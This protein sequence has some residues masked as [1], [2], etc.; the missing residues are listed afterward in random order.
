MTDWIEVHRGWTV[1]DKTGTQW[2]VTDRKP[3]QVF[4]IS[5]PGKKT[6][7]G[8]F[9]GEVDAV[10]P[11]PKDDERLKHDIATAMI[12]VRLGGKS[13]GK[14]PK[15]RSLPWP[16]PVDF[17]EPGTMLAHLMIFHGH[18]SDEP[19]LAVLRKVHDGLHDPT[20]KTGDLYEPHIHDPD[21]LEL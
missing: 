11:D 5:A 16:V 1:T 7:T 3:G 20:V 15:D 4:T 9:F 2:T 10:G 14:Q 6:F 18:K 12:E 13:V 17:M 8:P 21:Y 19:S